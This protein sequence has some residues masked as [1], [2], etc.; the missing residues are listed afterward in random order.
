[1]DEK[2]EEFLPPTDGWNNKVFTVVLRA[3]NANKGT[4]KFVVNLKSILFFRH[5]D[6]VHL[7]F[8]RSKT[9][10]FKKILH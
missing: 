6:R 9:I 1:M 5:D 10:I 4:E 8:T 7:I 3:T 2:G